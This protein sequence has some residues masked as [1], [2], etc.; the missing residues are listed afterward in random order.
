VGIRA[1]GVFFNLFARWHQWCRSRAG[2][3]L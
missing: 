1:L 2:K 3:N